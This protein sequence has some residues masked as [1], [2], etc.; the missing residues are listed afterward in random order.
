MRAPRLL[1]PCLLLLLGLSPK[2]AAY[3]QD[4]AAAAAA[5][6]EIVNTLREAEAAFARGRPDYILA[7]RALEQAEATDDLRLR[8]RANRLQARLDSAGRRYSRAMPYFNRAERYTRQADAAEAS[9][10]VEAAKAEAAE[11][12]AARAEAVAA[13][14]EAEATLEE[15]RAA[16]RWKYVTVV[17]ICLAVLAAGVLGFLATV[18]K[19]RGDVSAAERRQAESDTGYGEARTQLGLSSRTALNR[20]RRIVQSISTRM[21]AGAAGSPARDLA[22]QAAALR[23]VSQASF[24]QGGKHEVAMEAFFDKLDGALAEQLAPQPGVRLHTESMPVRLS[25]DQAVPLAL[26]YTELVG[27][28]FKHGGGDV[29]AKLTKEGTSVTLTVADAAAR[30][31]G[32]E[33]AREGRKLVAFLADELKARVDYPSTDGGAVRVRFATDGVRGPAV[34]I[35]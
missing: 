21:P 18:R 16:A 20:L 9:A 32:A 27:N 1:L 30:G 25:L 8:A 14:T 13:R 19:L 7:R 5:N 4:A 28:A 15:E 11:A 12:E 2:P 31:F 10:A 29:H 35:G 33:P 3:A 26:I 22:A 23:S 24:E 17:G 34:G 6:T